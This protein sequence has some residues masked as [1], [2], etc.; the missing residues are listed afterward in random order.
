MTSAPPAASARVLAGTV[1]HERRS[2]RRHAFRYRMW[3][4]DLDLDA[5]DE[6]VGSLRVLGYERGR[7]LRFDRRDYL[8]PHNVPLAEAVRD[9]VADRLG[10]RPDGSIRLLA[11]LRTFGWCFNP[12][13]VFLCHDAAGRLES[14]VC[15]VT[16]TP[17]KE[18]HQYVFAAGPEGV[19]DHVEPKALHVSPFMPMDQR[20]RFSLRDEPARF[21]LRIDT[22]DATGETFAAGV[23]L[24]AAPMRDAALASALVR[25]PFLTLRVSLGIHTQAARLWRRR[26]PLHPHPRRSRLSRPLVPR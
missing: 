18:R 20:Y 14:V 8:G 6:T 10:H 23:D 3:W 21:V 19:R 4:A 13:V 17:W 25:H 11:H 15:D 24:V 26:I 9:L 7:P 22:L 5:L 2:P 12:I 1:W 16:N